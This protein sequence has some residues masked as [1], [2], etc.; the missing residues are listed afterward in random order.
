MFIYSKKE[1]DLLLH[2]VAR[3]SDIEGRTNIVPDEN[4]IQCSSLKMENGKTFAPH[5]HIKKERFYKE[6][7]AQ[8][9]WVVIKGKVKCKFYDIDDT[10]IAE[11]ILEA[12]DTSFTLYGGHTYEIMEDNTIV[13][14]YKTGPYE[15]QKY[16]KVFI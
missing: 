12:G 8:E 16:D 2:I 10:L 13:Y 15:G 9:S 4:F 11:P 1:P 5:K 14:E 7:I 6:Q 3:F